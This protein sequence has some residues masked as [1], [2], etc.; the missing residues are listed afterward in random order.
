MCVSTTGEGWPW[1]V[2]MRFVA[3]KN[4]QIPIAKHQLPLRL[5][6]TH[7]P[8]AMLDTRDKA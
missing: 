6:P 2:L 1:G 3:L 5:V 4:S 7:H 8:S